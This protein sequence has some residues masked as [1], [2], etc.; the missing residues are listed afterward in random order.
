[1]ENNLYHMKVTRESINNIGHIGR[2]VD[3]ADYLVKTA[4]LAK[5]MKERERLEKNFC[6]IQKFL[7]R[8]HKY[9]LIPTHDILH[10]RKF[11]SITMN[12][13]KKKGFEKVTEALSVKTKSF[14]DGI[15]KKMAL[16]N[17]STKNK[18]YY[19]YELI[20]FKKDGNK[21]DP[22][23]IIIRIVRFDNDVSHSLIWVGLVDNQF[24]IIH[25]N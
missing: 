20:M 9:M 6:S 17:R 21:K 10:G 18:I 7:D 1:M 24:C 2:G 22:Y 25:D 16:Q 3:F 8:K 5:E 15:Q 11:F 13:I 23:D 14:V 19:D 4:K 12:T